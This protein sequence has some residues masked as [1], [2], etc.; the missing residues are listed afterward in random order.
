MALT[1]APHRHRLSRA[2]LLAL[3]LLTI[4]PALQ[5]RTIADCDREATHTVLHP[6]GAVETS[7]DPQAVWLSA[8]RLV[9][10][11][12][13]DAPDR[14]YRLVFSSGASLVVRPGEPVQGADGALVLQRESRPLPERIARR[15]RHVAPG[16]HLGTSAGTAPLRALHRAQVL[17][18]QEDGTGRVLRAT[19]LQHPG[20]LDDLYADAARAT[21]LGATPL[22]RGGFAFALWAPSAQRVSLCLHAGPSSPAHALHP[23]HLDPRTGIWSA[24]VRE[25][26]KGGVGP[27]YRYLVDVH[28]P[29]LGI[30]RNR[31]TDPYS[32]SLSADSVRSLALDLDAPATK[33]P[34]WDAHRTPATVQAP[35]DAV[36][37][38][39]H[40][41]DFSAQ[42]RSVR[43]AWRG[44]YLAFTE[45]DSHGMRHLRAL[46]RAGLT[47]VHLLPVFDLASVPE[48]DCVTPAPTGAPDGEA[49]QA[50]V[51]ALRERDCFNWGYDP[52]HYT[53]PEGSYASDA[54]DGAVRIREFR[55]MV[56][57]LHRAGLRVGMDVVYN[58][59]SASGQADKS[60]L[61]RIVPGY[62]HRLDARGARPAAR[63][64][65]P[66]TA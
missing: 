64:P 56:L 37:Y 6:A 18:V 24:A 5:A 47:D 11:Q 27:H 20:A 34:G 31:V 52:W 23:M 21:E 53:A 22:R 60:V 12:L 16:L 40:V 2:L 46:A 8:R 19:A 7:P 4:W 41:R 28:V 49:Q 33:P 10:P 13:T 65:R 50:A 26:A 32:L 1:D 66:S 54:R 14:R 15:Y 3:V 45:P 9:W 38:E 29:G 62:Y 63:T 61:D 17:L 55:A 36:I 59:T 51:V 35:V 57:G 43:E 30:V 48:T 39:L 58:H 44:K 25:R 42:D